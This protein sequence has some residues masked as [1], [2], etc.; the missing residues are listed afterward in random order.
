MGRHAPGA[1]PAVRA[2]SFVA[3][4][5]RRRGDRDRGARLRGRRG[6]R[7]GRAG[8]RPDRAG[9]ARRRTRPAD[10]GPRL[11]DRRSIGRP[12]Q[13]GREPR[14]RAPGPVPTALARAVLGGPGR[15]SAR[16]RDR[17]PGAVRHA[18]PSRGHVAQA[19]RRSNRGRARGDPH[20]R[21]DHGDHRHGRSLPRRRAERRARGR[22]HDRAG[23]PDRATDRGRRDL[24]PGGVTARR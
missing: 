6:R 15:R 22:R 23:R 12:L 20:R 2:R 4:A 8:G 10:R 19:R 16:G 18:P 24:N 11:R 14:V 9:G 21:P 1:E 7:D 13:P 3:A 17:R 5:D